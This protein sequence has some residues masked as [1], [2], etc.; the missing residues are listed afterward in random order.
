MLVVAEKGFGSA[1]YSSNIAAN[2]ELRQLPTS[3]LKSKAPVSTPEEL[4][5]D[6][7]AS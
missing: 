4:K 1:H 2:F 5:L 6:V 3:H 7:G